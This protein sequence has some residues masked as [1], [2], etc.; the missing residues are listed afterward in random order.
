MKIPIFNSPLWHHNLGTEK[1]EREFPL[2]SFSQDPEQVDL[3]VHG[4]VFEMNQ[5]FSYYQFLKNGYSPLANILKTD[6]TLNTYL[7]E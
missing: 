6:N 7:N 5:N 4:E 1:D 2:V 3:F